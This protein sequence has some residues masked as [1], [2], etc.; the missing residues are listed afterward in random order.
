MACL[1][2]L[3]VS[4]MWMWLLVKILI[5]HTFIA[6]LLKKLIFWNEKFE[7]NHMVFEHGSNYV[8]WQGSIN[9]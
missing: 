6:F 8:K 2:I 9:L 7:I 4:S 3:L 5:Y 1:T